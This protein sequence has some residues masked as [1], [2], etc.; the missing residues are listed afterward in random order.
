MISER[1]RPFVLVFATLAAS[2]STIAAEPPYLAHNPFARPAVSEIRVG[3]NAVD[4]K[5][6]FS[7]DL[8]L[9]ATLVSGH[10]RL[11]N[12]NGR[13]MR[14]GDEIFGYALQRV[15]ENRAVFVKNGKPTTV[16]V[17]PKL[18]ENYDSAEANQDAD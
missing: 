12:V 17:K 16:Y 15:F 3:R 2:T 14:A 5:L 10:R 8:K 6:Q 18:E 13:V 11:A 4:N 7:D 1:I 9:K